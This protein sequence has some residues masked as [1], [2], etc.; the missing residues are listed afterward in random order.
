[1]PGY[2]PGVSTK[3]MMGRPNLERQFH[4]AHCLAIAFRI[5]HAEIAE[6]LLLGIA[7]LLIAH[8]DDRPILELGEAGHQC[9]IIREAAVAVQLQEIRKQ[10][11]NI[12][13]SIGPLGMARQ[14][15]T[16]PGVLV[17]AGYLLPQAGKLLAHA[18][19]LFLQRGRSWR[20]LQLRNLLFEFLGHGLVVRCIYHIV[21]RSWCTLKL[22]GYPTYLCT[23]IFRLAY[24]YT[25]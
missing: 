3:Q 24:H 1:M 10:H 9:G 16:V 22:T 8:H 19:N 14:Q 11:L 2:A 5:G 4:D 12:V 17:G 23:W 13:E 20:F 7:S 21:G 25:K 6:Q 15:H 18:L